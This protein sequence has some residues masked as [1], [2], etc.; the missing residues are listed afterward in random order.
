MSD[1]KLS[2][3]LAWLIR[4]SYKDSGL[5]GGDVDCDKFTLVINMGAFDE[6]D[7]PDTLLGWKVGVNR[8]SYTDHPIMLT[9]TVDDSY[10]KNIRKWLK[11]FYELQEIYS[12]Y[13]DTIWMEETYE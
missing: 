3:Y 1:R 2:D 6:E 5:K 10:D 11:C 8:N 12:F 9:T 7:I 13:Y 4:N